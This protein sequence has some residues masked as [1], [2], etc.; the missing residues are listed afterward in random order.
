MRYLFRNFNHQ[1]TEQIKSMQQ[2]G[3]KKFGGAQKFKKGFEVND[4]GISSV[5]ED[6]SGRSGGG[7]FASN[8]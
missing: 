1:L 3:S 2:T 4:A 5:F 8:Y 7:L 6:D